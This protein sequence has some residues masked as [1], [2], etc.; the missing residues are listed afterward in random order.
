[1]RRSAATIRPSKEADMPMSIR[2]FAIRCA[3]IS[4]L[5]AATAVAAAPAEARDAVRDCG[6]SAANGAG[7]FAITAQGRGLTCATARGVARAVPPKR[8][9]S[10]ETID[11]CTVRGYQCFVAQVGKELYLV[12]CANAKQTKFVRFEF[13][14]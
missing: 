5:G 3:V 6:D 13:G 9:C 14:S 2:R 8:S 1:V 7:S 4:A 10:N 11:S 12:R